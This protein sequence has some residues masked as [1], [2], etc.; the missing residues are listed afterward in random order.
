MILVW[1][2]VSIC[3]AIATKK[4]VVCAFKC[5]TVVALAKLCVFG[6]FILTHSAAHELDSLEKVTLIGR[7]LQTKV[8]AIML[9]N[10]HLFPIDRLDKNIS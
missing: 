10:F 9:Q 8:L 3:V 2:V 1:F 6:L 7:G 4:Q 5:S